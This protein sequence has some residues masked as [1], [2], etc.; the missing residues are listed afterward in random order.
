MQKTYILDKV[1]V[2]RMY[3]ILSKL[4]GEKA[5]NPHLEKGQKTCTDISLKRLHR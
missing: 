1:L 3:S 2:S 5:N 4:N